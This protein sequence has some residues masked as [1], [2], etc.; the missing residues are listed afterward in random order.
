MHCCGADSFRDWLPVNWSG[1]GMN[2]IPKSCCA[3]VGGCP[4]DSIP[5]PLPAEVVVW[6]KVIFDV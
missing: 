1:D 6:R 3:T 4:N 5:Y 2:L